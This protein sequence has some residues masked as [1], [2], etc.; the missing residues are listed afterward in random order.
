MN[1]YQL[2]FTEIQEEA[3]VCAHTIIQALKIYCRATGTAIE[4]LDETDRI[5]ILPQSE[6]INHFIRWDDQKETCFADFLNTNPEPC[7][8]AE[9]STK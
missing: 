6:W 7:L 9:S 8:I 5:V 2:E 1:I 3:W 4:E